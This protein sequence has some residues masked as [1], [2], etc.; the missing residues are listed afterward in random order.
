MATEKSRRKEGAGKGR[1]IATDRS[2]GV[3]EDFEE[4]SKIIE[5]QRTI[6]KD[7]GVGGG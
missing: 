3:S 5:S 1:R 4:S 2:I 6:V 7:G